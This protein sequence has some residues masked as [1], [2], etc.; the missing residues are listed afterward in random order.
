M[1]GKF[2]HSEAY[3]FCK[4]C[5]HHHIARNTVAAF[6]N[7]GLQP[8]DIV[9]VT[10]I[11]CHG[12]VDRC[13][14]TH[15]IHGLHG[16]SVAMGVGV[17]LALPANKKVV[18]FIG[19]GGATIGL[20]HILE[21][22][23]LNVDMTVVVH[24]NMLYGMTGGQPSGLTPCGY[25]TSITPQG[26][27]LPNHDLCQLVI[28]AGASFT[29]RV[30][31]SGDFSTSLQKAM[32]TPGF[33]LVEVLELCTSYGTKL[34]P[35]LRL[36]QLAEEG[37]YK[38]GSWE[39]T[40]RDCLRLQSKSS[41][42][43]LE[44]PFIEPTYPSNLDKPCSIVVGGSAGEGVQSAAEIL[45]RAAISSGLHVTKKSSYPVTVQVGF[46][47]A[48]LI[49]SSQPILCHA[50][51]QPDV[52]LITSAD[53]LQHNLKRIKAMRTG[54]L[55]IDASLDPP[56]SAAKIISGDFRRPAGER[57]AAILTLLAWVKQ[58]GIISI[59]CLLDTIECSPLAKHIKIEKLL[60]FV[61]EQS[62]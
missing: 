38:L 34:N 50:F 27:Q 28:D 14:R 55:F 4:G 39:K 32:Q 46:S 45:A 7:L 21:A 12:I 60:S 8:L 61:N 18:V 9:L 5:G 33:A 29:A 17:A 3:P 40:H 51:D 43:L 16:R 11:G 20:Q 54:I 36:H 56:A 15:T 42:S 57:N 31:G 19:D 62:H 48:D 26:N 30:I 35:E 10:D 2:V 22:A 41:N 37:G 49:I 1:T 58:S 6:E 44:I 53:G 47:T 24:N 23:R 13:F 25:R 52:A 59:Q